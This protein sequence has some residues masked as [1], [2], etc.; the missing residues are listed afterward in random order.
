MARA[1]LVTEVEERKGRDVL[2]LRIES[3]ASW[4]ERPAPPPRDWICEDLGIAAGRVTSLY[5]N[6]GLGK[7]AISIQAGVCI[8]ASHPLY[9]MQVNGGPVLGIFCED[10]QAEIERR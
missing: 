1:E 3:A 7:T 6:G 5:G 9:G 4:A 2:A 8:A 10:E